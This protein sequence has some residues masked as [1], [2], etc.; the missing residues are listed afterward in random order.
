MSWLEKNRQRRLNM[1]QIIAERARLT[2]NELLA[3]VVGGRTY[4][5]RQFHER[6]MEWAAALSRHGVKRGDHVVTFFDPHF[7]AYALWV[8]LAW[9]GAVDVPFNPAYRGNVLRHGLNMSDAKLAVLGPGYV[10]RVSE[11]YDPTTMF[12]T[13]LVIGDA[14]LAHSDDRFTIVRERDFFAGLKPIEESKLV[15]PKAHD[16]AC[17]IFTSGTTGPAKAVLV[18]WGQLIAASFL[19]RPD[20]ANDEEF[21]QNDRSVFYA[22]MPIFHM[23]GRYGLAIS[24]FRGSKLAYRPTFSV[25]AFWKDVR[26]FGCTHAQVLT[27]MMAF[28][29]SKAPSADDRDHGLI[30]VNGGP[31]SPIIQQFI[32]RFGVRVRSGFGMTE[33]G[34]P[35]GTPW[36]KTAPENCG[37]PV[38]GSPGYELMIVDENDY[39]VKPGDVGEL[40]V[41]TR[42]PWATNAGYYKM[43]EVTARAW[44]NGWFHTGDAFRI[45][46]NNKY[47]FVDRKKDCIR[48]RGENISS[49]EVE[50]YV[51]QH[52]GV[53]G[54]AAVSHPSDYGVGE[55]E[56]KVFV[57]PNR[58]KL[59]SEK[60]LWSFLKDKMPKYMLPRYIEFVPAFPLTEATNR[61]Q[62]GKLKDQGDSKATWDAL[63]GA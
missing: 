28:L 14:E 37:D 27:P 47:H 48:R 63:S 43:P 23:S 61:I 10:E 45:D 1:P 25:D 4:T 30:A 58:E 16:I 8:A 52:P 2:P 19:G 40:I 41:R 12:D 36:M 51:T 49:F 21:N 38:V 20:A 18:P 32:D 46:E 11:V 57:I 13:A 9:L 50:S 24:V 56:V 42:E 6:I 35:L 53:V 22:Y 7:D 59:N 5:Y 3:S 62:K 39:P 44:R 60:E 15:D 54:V 55:E 17:I 31:I 26:A 33:I 34:G 29:L